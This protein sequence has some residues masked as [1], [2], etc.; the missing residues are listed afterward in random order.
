M[1]SPHSELTAPNRS[2]WRHK[3]NAMVASGHV[4]VRR[5]VPKDSNFGC[6]RKIAAPSGFMTER[7]CA[8]SGRD[9]ILLPASQ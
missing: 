1:R 9:I 6:H 2:I 7:V 8:L 4:I 5:A 3:N